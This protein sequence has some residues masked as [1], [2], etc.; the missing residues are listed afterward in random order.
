MN[1]Y[2]DFRKVTFIT[3]EA[4]RENR[5][6]GLGIFG[7]LGVIVWLIIGAAYCSHQAHAQPAYVDDKFEKILRDYTYSMQRADVLEETCKR[8]HPGQEE[9]CAKAAAELRNQ[10]GEAYIA[11]TTPRYPVPI[12]PSMP[13]SNSG[14]TS[15]R[16][17]GTGPGRSFVCNSR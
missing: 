12:Q 4:K 7:W 10:L 11:A 8:N 1:W 15:C 13:Q 5:S 16:W 2:N 3:N 9:S 17:I 14:T 6:K